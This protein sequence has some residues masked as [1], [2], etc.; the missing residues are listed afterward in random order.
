METMNMHHRWL[1]RRS[2]IVCA[3]AIGLCAVNDAAASGSAAEAHGAPP[4]EEEVIESDG[5]IRGISLGDFR[6]Q[7]YHAVEAKRSTLIFTLHAVVSSEN[8]P[9]FKQLIENRR[10][11]VRDQ[12]ITIARMASLADFD[13]PKLADFRRRILLR[14]RRIMPEL[15]IDDLYVSDFQ[16]EVRGI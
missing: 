16:L 3:W 11:K 12:V 7:A 6:I 9:E 10:H 15:K 5:P 13:Q 8:A 14:L 1:R 2:V 4:A